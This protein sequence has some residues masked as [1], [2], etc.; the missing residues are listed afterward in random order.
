M[1]VIRPRAFPIDPLPGLV[2]LNQWLWRDVLSAVEQFLTATD[3][4]IVIGKPSVLALQM[5][6]LNA[7]VPSVYDAM[8]DFPAFY[9]G[10]SRRAMERH[11]QA[12][13][14]K[15]SKILV[16]STALAAR[17]NIYQSKVSFVPN[18]YSAQYVPTKNLL[19][20]RIGQPVLG[21]VGTIGFWFDWPL[22]IA[23]ANAN[24]MLRVRLIGPVYSLPITDLPKN[25]ELLPACD[26]AVAMHAMQEFSVGLI[27]F[28]LG[29]LTASVDPIKYYEYRA[30]GLPV[31]STCFGEMALRADQPGVV[32]VNSHEDLAIVLERALEYKPNINEI[33]KFQND[34]TWEARFDA[35]VNLSCFKN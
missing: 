27:P 23:L 35:I 25:I 26:H 31:I 33:Q 12:V 15:V 21:Y 3:G 5:L 17:F 18:A 9:V 30:L 4:L 6:I 10:L 13:A 34:N 22:V 7:D 8:D 16:S 2:F 1:R 19:S 11:E 14:I 24:P 29:D 32:L 28:K 20:S